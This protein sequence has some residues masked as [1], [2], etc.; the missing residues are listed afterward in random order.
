VGE[1]WARGELQ[2]FEEHLYSEVMLNLLRSTLEP[3][4]SPSGK[5]RVLMTTVHEESH[6]L[7][8]LRQPAPLFWPARIAAIWGRRYRSMTLAT[9]RARMTRMS[10]PCLSVRPT[11]GAG[12]FP[13]YRNYV[14]D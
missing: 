9:P 10:S 6:S 14:S 11:R 7:G 3:L 2:V 1:A 12:F 4:D 8:L 5:P 13:C